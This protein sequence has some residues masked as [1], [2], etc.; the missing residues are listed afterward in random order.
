[1]RG[2][3]VEETNKHQLEGLLKA[4]SED[5]RNGRR[6]RSRGPVPESV[7]GPRFDGSEDVNGEA[8]GRP[9]AECGT[10]IAALRVRAMPRATRCLKCQRVAEAAPARS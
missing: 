10:E 2:E 9:C 7:A 4:R 5:M 8:S 1:M 6:P 3:G